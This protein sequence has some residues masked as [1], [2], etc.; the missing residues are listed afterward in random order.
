MGLELR[1]GACAFMGEYLHCWKP[2]PAVGEVAEPF[3]FGVWD[4]EFG[5]WDLGFWVWGLGVWGLRSEV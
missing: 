2:A 1:V 5:V 3:G 4:L